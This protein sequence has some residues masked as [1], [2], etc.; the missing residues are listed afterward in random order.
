MLERAD[1]ELLDLVRGRARR[2]GERAVQPAAEH[3][4]QQRERRRA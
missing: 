1:A 2:L 3:P 4:A